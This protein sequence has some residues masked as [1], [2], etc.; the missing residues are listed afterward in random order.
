M[1]N[2]ARALMCPPGVPLFS[3]AYLRIFLLVRQLL[4]EVSDLLHQARD[5]GGLF[6]Q[7]RD[8]GNL[9]NQA[10]DGS[11]LLHQARD[12]GKGFSHR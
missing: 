11:G 1:G 7:V 12:S 4:P 2:T 3:S 6:H 5:G 9:F 8:S 10:R